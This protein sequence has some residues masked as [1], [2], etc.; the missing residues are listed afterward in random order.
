[1]IQK[2]QK[3]N[4]EPKEKD[5]YLIVDGL[6]IVFEMFTGTDKGDFSPRVDQLFLLDLGHTVDIYYE[7]N[8]RIKE[9]RINKLLQYL[10]LDG[11]NVYLRSKADRYVGYFILAATGVLL[12]ICLLIWK[13]YVT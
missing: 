1:M 12:V 13:K 6:D 2:I 4:S 8:N 3:P 11:E 9:Q 7:V 5:V 10:D